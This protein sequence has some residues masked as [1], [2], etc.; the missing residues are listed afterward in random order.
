MS[1]GTSQPSDLMMLP[2]V[3]LAVL[4][5]AAVVFWLMGRFGPR[6]PV[7]TAVPEPPLPRPALPDALTTLREAGVDTD[8][9]LGPWLAGAR[10]G[11]SGHDHEER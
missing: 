9:L 6:T 7:V 10:T 2:V 1:E 5:V 4:A 8:A 3:F 11:H